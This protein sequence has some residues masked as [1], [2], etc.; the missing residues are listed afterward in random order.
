MKSTI[1]VVITATFAMFITSGVVALAT[2][3][4]PDPDKEAHI[5]EAFVGQMIDAHYAEAV[6][7]IKI[8]TR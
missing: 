2:A 7:N 5:A 3:A 8:P 6:F 4:P 1:Y